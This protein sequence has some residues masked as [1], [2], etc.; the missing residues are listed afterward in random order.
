MC[1]RAWPRSKSFYI[2]SP[3]ATKQ[4]SDRGLL[5]FH[6]LQQQL[7]V[8]Q[9]LLSK[10]LGHGRQSGIDL[11][12]GQLGNVTFIT[13]RV[14]Q[15]TPESRNLQH[16]RPSSPKSQRGT[17]R[18][19]DMLRLLNR[20]APIQAKRRSDK[21]LCNFD[22]GSPRTALTAFAKPAG[23]A[24]HK[25]ESSMENGSKDQNPERRPGMLV[26]SLMQLQKEKSPKSVPTRPA[27]LRRGA[28]EEDGGEKPA[29]A[30][31]RRKRQRKGRRRPKPG[32]AARN[33]A[34]KFNAAS[35]GKVT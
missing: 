15:T 9:C 23:N 31:H 5:W 19:C 21:A 33:T 29:K 27:G 20:K 12:H 30:M 28:E 35:K 11:N 25:G 1:F 18:Y 8:V 17:S 2:T 34:V 22:P 32:S 10:M 3:K 6:T 14:A 13:P 16:I 7:K 26:S 4:A 24:E